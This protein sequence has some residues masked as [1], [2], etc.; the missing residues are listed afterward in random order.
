MVRAVRR[1]FLVYL[2]GMATTGIVVVPF[3]L[4]F[5]LSEGVSAVV[6]GFIYLGYALLIFLGFLVLLTVLGVQKLRVLFGALI[7][8][9]TISWQYFAYVLSVAG[10]IA[11]ISGSKIQ[12]PAPDT[13]A[14]RGGAGL[15]A[16]AFVLFLEDFLRA[17]GFPPG[18]GLSERP[19]IHAKTRWVFIAMA[20]WASFMAG[21]RP[22]YFALPIVMSTVCLM[23]FSVIV[24]YKMAGSAFDSATVARSKAVRK[25]SGA[26]WGIH[27][28]DV[29]VT[30]K[31]RSRVDGG[32][33]G[34]ERLQECITTF[35]EEPPKFVFITGDLT[36][37]GD[38]EE[39]EEARKILAPLKEKGTRIVI[40]PG[41]HDL[42]TA[43]NSADAF[44][45]TRLTHFRGG[46]VRGMN[47]L[48]LRAFLGGLAALEPD[49]KNAKGETIAA[50]LKREDKALSRLWGLVEEVRMV[51]STSRSAKLYEAERFRKKAAK[52]FPRYP[53]SMGWEALLWTSKESFDD[54]YVSSLYAERW[55]DYFPLYLVDEAID[56]QVIVLNSIARDPT[57]IGSAWG[58]LGQDQI[59][60]LEEIIRT[61][62]SRQFVILAHHAPFRWHDESPPDFSLEEIQRWACLAVSVSS[63]NRFSEILSRIQRDKKK[64]FFFCGHRHGGKL[65]EARIGDWR[66]GQVVEGA[67]LADKDARI[68]AAWQESKGKLRLGMIKN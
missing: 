65:H 58:D 25:R 57:L 32:K 56:A 15:A 53:P 34:N 51:V 46:M 44:I 61:S 19:A 68:L 43:Y 59:G 27:W 6:K 45:S 67:S 21:F 18:A 29:H 16:G 30:R 11:L 23:A 48:R 42:A 36:D 5:G 47:G 28:T 20:L 63:V 9:F 1:A 7:A 2:R 40:V 35:L 10:I 62:T 22:S 52:L 8:S 54:F 60:R 50:I 14:A 41:N 38:E 55:Q 31:G 37:R 26:A 13:F 17:L 3:L 4:L 24:T 66:G 33:G 12:L 64:F 39:W 49:L